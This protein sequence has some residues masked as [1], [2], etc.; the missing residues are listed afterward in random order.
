MPTWFTTTKR[1]ASPRIRST[2][3]SREDLSEYVQPFAGRN[4]IGRNH[5]RI[6]PA[7]RAAAAIPAG[8][9]DRVLPG[10]P[11]SP[12]TILVTGPVTSVDSLTAAPAAAAT[13]GFRVRRQSM[14]VL[15]ASPTSVFS[16]QTT[17]AIRSSLPGA[18]SPST[19]FHQPDLMSVSDGPP[20]VGLKYAA[21]WSSS[22]LSR[23]TA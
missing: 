1:M 15:P 21:V 12:S 9:P 18:A 8:A 19:C 3:E 13:S 17:A 22:G 7:S 23:L 20:A 2:R 14:M 16:S 11:P 6:A 10:A 5:S 4:R